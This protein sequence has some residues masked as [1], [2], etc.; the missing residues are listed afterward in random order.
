MSC[1]IKLQYESYKH[2]ES[3]ILKLSTT[4][5]DTAS[6]TSFTSLSSRVTIPQALRGN[7]MKIQECLTS[8]ASFR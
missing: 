8:K 6:L 5:L 1:F 4:N 3:L 2:Q 7:G